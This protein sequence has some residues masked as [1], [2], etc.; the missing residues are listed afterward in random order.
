MALV[1]ALSPYGLTVR[2]DT[3]SGKYRFMKGALM[4]CKI[5]VDRVYKGVGIQDT[6]TVLTSSSDAACGY[7]FGVGNTYI[8]YGKKSDKV[9][10]YNSTG[11]NPTKR[12]VYWTSVCTRTTEWFKSEEDEIEAALKK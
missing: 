1:S 5:S 9:L 2:G 12:G 8:V 6:V 3:T 4:L 7:R 10:I 11:T